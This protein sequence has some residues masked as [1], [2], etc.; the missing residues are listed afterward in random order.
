MTRGAVTITFLRAFIR[1]NIFVGTSTLFL[2]QLKALLCP[3]H[4]NIGVKT[5]DSHL[6]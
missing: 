1:T 5:I 6:S 2:P 3:G 4:F